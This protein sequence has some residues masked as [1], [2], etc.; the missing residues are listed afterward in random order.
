M[1]GAEGPSVPL[2][3]LEHCLSCPVCQ[4]WLAPSYVLG[5]GHLLCSHC[6]VRWLSIRKSCPVC[7]CD[8][9][10]PPVRCPAV[11]AVVERL[12]PAMAPADRH[13]VESRVRAAAASKPLLDGLFAP[14][15]WR[16]R[17]QQQRQ[18]QE[19]Q[20]QQQP[21][22]A[23]L[24]ALALDVLL[25]DQ[26][27]QQQHEAEES[28]RHSDLQRSSLPGAPISARIL[29]DEFG[30]FRL[31]GMD[32]SDDDPD[33][34]ASAD[35]AEEAYFAGLVAQS[36][37]PGGA[38]A[39][40]PAPQQPQQPQQQPGAA[41]APVAGPRPAGRLRGLIT[42]W[43][44]EHGIPAGAGRRPAASRAAA[45]AVAATAAELGIGVR[46]HGGGGGGGGGGAAGR[47]PAHLEHPM[48]SSS[49]SSSSAS[50]A[51]IMEVDAP[52][53]GSWQG[54]SPHQQS[55]QQSQQQA[56]PR[57][58]P[59]VLGSVAANMARYLESRPALRQMLQSVP[60]A[61][62]SA[63]AELFQR[64]RSPASLGVR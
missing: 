11:D 14:H 54:H 46:L 59:E 5:C 8:L 52:G 43:L 19:R 6:S 29:Q 50:L 42:G 44:S 26:Q 34:A 38:L 47:Q 20:Q 31:V 49:A 23:P 40:Q 45:A 32:A 55:Q 60:R 16:P 62:G 2:L 4:D 30:T 17:Q 25:P 56:P 58:V 27:Q 9:A 28:P 48:P 57:Q 13:R 15:K 24:A 33:A 53:A 1:A 3:L 36:H 39:P 21:R 51:S 18:Q 22:S 41:G 61:P 10:A 63:V 64:L 37:H 7:R 35:E 12:L